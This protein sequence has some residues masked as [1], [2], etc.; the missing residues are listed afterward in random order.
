MLFFCAYFFDHTGI[1]SL[2]I[3]NLAAW[4]GIAVTPTQILKANDFNSS[5][6]IIT[7]LLLGIALI[8]AGKLTIIRKIKS[9]FGF[10]YTNFGMHILFISCLA[11][12]FHFDAVYF[13]WFLALLAIA[14]Y[15]YRE[16]MRTKSFYFLLML[17]LYSYTGLSYVV[18]YFLFNTIK[19]DIGGVYLTLFYF[20]GSAT[21][22]ILF[23]IRMN[24]KLKA[25]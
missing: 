4:V 13:L 7:T 22:L 2:A 24:K 11:G 6:I 19:T 18:V 14:F 20:I 12:L 21:G 1:L 10:T 3:T 15:F 16:A 25:A 8:L 23:L 9:H 5:T 17:T